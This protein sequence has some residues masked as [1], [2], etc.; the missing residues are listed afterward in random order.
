MGERPFFIRTEGD[1]DAR[2]W[3]AT[4]DDVPGRASWPAHAPPAF[5]MAC[6]SASHGIR[7][8]VLS[9]ELGLAMQDV[10]TYHSVHE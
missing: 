1:E 4:S 7:S 5:R 10:N 8:A 2:V 6:T 3:V 9:R